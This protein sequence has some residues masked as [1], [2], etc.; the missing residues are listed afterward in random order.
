MKTIIV[1][2]DFSPAATNA[3]NYAA[4]MAL[5]IH[6]GL[7]LF[8]TY[9][10]PIGYGEM[11]VISNLDAMLK[12]AENEM[13]ATKSQIIRQKGDK[14]LITSAIRM[15]DFFQELKILCEETKPYTVVMGSQGTT[16][17]ERFLFGGHAT[18]TMKHLK[19]PLITVPPGA[20]FSSIKKIGLACD[21][22]QVVATTPVDEIKKLVNDFKAQLLILHTGSNEKFDPEEVFES[23]MLQEMLGPVK[24]KYHFINHENVDEGI[25]DFTEKNQVDLLL[26][27][28]KRHNLVEKLVHKSHTKH[29][30]LHSHVPVMAL[31]E[32]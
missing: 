15:G 20:S 9:Q 8:H 24:P 19:W 23:G 12:T 4:D 16:A 7:L 14:L 2:T 17:A 11:P 26:V 27:L 25:L 32:E 30:V 22:N 1:A 6:A 29:L 10:V 5:K 3:M 13:D 18:Y 21:F 31:H 28:P